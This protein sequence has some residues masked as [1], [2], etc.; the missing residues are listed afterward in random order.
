MAGS[1]YS[2]REYNAQSHPDS[3]T[4]HVRD[5]IHDAG[6]AKRLEDL[7]CFNSNREERGKQ[8]RPG[9]RLRAGLMPPK[10]KVPHSSNGHI[11]GHIDRYVAS[12]EPVYP[13][14][15]RGEDQT[16]RVLARVDPTKIPRVQ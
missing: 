15:P 2:V 8:N 16:E 12:N 5:D 6:G 10:R 3:G 13:E 14:H 11:N 7:K 9:Q 1:V 4:G